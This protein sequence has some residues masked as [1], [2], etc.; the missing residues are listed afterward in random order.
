MSIFDIFS[1]IKSPDQAPSGAVEYI[2]AGL[3]NPGREYAANRHNA[4]FMAIDY[5]ARELAVPV[6][7]LR[8][9]S[10]TGEAVIAG[11]KCLLIKPSN[12]MNKSGESVVDAMGY[13]KIPIQKVIVI[14]DDVSLDPGRI[15]IRS[16]GSDGGQ[17]GVKNIIYLTGSDDFPRIKIGIGQKPHPDYDLASWVLSDF[18]RSEQKLI[19]SVCV[20][21]LE[22]VK[23]IVGGDITQAMNGYN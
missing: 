3:G 17:K 21:C 13:Y 9:K 7:K 16:K 10:L 14:F 22:A 15:R 5:I 23:L 4:G 8:F 11:K 18:T 2:I 1:K 20:D 19:D 12:Y 6:K